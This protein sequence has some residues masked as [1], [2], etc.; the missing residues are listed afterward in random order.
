MALEYFETNGG[1]S[2]ERYI[3]SV[4]YPKGKNRVPM[5]LDF[6][7]R[8]SCPSVIGLYFL[9]CNGKTLVTDKLFLLPL[10]QE[11]QKKFKGAPI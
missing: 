3:F 10:K 11:V 7:V 6:A 5:Y 9:N 4:P 1:A 2:D 8:L